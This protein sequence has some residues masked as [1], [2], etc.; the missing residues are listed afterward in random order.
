MKSLIDRTF[1]I[2]PMMDWTDR[3]YR[4]FMRLISKKVF[5]YTEMINVG[6]IIFGDK[7]RFLKFDPS[8]HPIAVQL[9]G[10]QSEQ[11]AEAAKIC[12]AYGYDEINLNVGCPSERVQAGRFGACLMAEPELVAECVFAMQKEVKIPVTVKTRIGIDDKDS[13]AELTH[14]IQTVQA[15]GCNT[16]IIHARKAWLNGLSP[17]EN[18]SIPP[19]KYDVVYQL[20]K[21]FPD[22]E[23]IIN[24]GIK[25]LSDVQ[26]HLQHTDGVMI[27]REA[28]SNP[29]FIAEIEQALFPDTFVDKTRMDILNEFIPYLEREMTV[30]VPLKT[31]TR[32]ILGLYQGMPNGRLWRG[33]LSSAKELSLASISPLPQ[34]GAGI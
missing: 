30:G 20:K 13:Y 22:L 24:G 15:A 16:F 14:F 17:K 29:M 21:D 34:V 11:L 6:A 1:S 32:H 3:H 18:R 4:Y 9:G 33:R 26:N 10:S 12:E 8:E 23:I 25:Y 28:Y 31:M 19:L 27:G 5:L 7:Q 2:A